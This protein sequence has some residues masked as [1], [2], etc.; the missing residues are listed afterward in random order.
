MKQ[1][2]HS[3]PLLLLFLTA[4]QPL[5]AQWQ[6]IHPQSSINQYF[7]AVVSPPNSSLLYAAGHSLAISSDGGNSWALQENFK[8]PPV[9]PASAYWDIC[10]TSTSTAFLVNEH[11]IFKTENTGASWKTVL[12]LSPNNAK[13]SSSAFFRSLFFVS[14]ETGF[15]VGDFN[16]I[17]KTTDGGDTW[18][19]LSWDSKTIPY[20]AITDVYFIDENVG[21]VSG[22]QSDD[23]VMNFGFTQFVMKTVD[24]GR[25]WQQVTIPTNWNFREINIQFLNESEGFAHL[26]NSQEY[27]ETYYTLD[28]GLS[29]TKNSP[30]N[31]RYIHKAYWQNNGKG[32]LYGI[33]QQSRILLYRTENLG[34][35]WEEVALPVFLY[36][37]VNIITDFLFSDEHKGVAVGS[38]GSILTTQDGGESWVSRNKAY[39]HFLAFKFY[40]HQTG[41]ASSGRGLFKTAD[42]GTNWQMVDG[43]VYLPIADF[44]LQNENNGVLPGYRGTAFKLTDGKLSKLDLPVTFL[45]RS[46]M[47]QHQDSLLICGTAIQPKGNFLLKS[48]DHGTT[49]KVLSIE[50]EGSIMDIEEVENSLYISQTSGI[51]KSDDGGHSW[52]KISSFSQDYLQHVTF[53]DAN[54]AVA[55]FSAARVCYSEDG[56]ATW[57]P[58]AQPF[59]NE[60][61]VYKFLAVNG[62]T[63]YACGSAYSGRTTYGRIWKSDDAGKSWTEEVIGDYIANGISDLQL[64]GGNLLASGGYGQFFRKSLGNR[65]SQWISFDALTE[66]TY[67]DADFSLSA[68][69]SS[70]LPV[71][72][73]SSNTSVATVNGAVVTIV[74]AGETIIRAHQP[75]NDLYEAAAVVAQPLTVHKKAQHISFN[76]PEEVN[77]GSAPIELEASSDAGL[78]LSFSSTNTAVATVDGNILSI[79]AP[80]ETTIEASQA[81]NNNYSPA[82]VAQALRVKVVTA[83]GDPAVA[84]PLVYPNPTSD[85][86]IFEAAPVQ[87]GAAVVKIYDG[88]GKLVEKHTGKASA[89]G[90]FTVDIRHLAP[91]IYTVMLEDQQI[92]SRRIVKIRAR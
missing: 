57:T 15:A 52:T 8:L 44:Y 56:G 34:Q 69:A 49:W 40:N 76:L 82:S 30:D 87:S 63:V 21:Y 2:K 29:W 20:R 58:V 55:Y 90:T 78:P 61:T 32:F 33:D 50:G 64:V 9:T 35:S 18:T 39:P 88:T 80:G 4:M 13:Y 19:T 38:G 75:G 65:Q 31:F 41:Y 53:L 5:L 70:A 77:A 27:D 83:A 92:I 46:Y 23:I 42:G 16:K 85:V 3:L 74:G 66:K 68:T 73:T 6:T 25:N 14:A 45:Y 72:Y 36:Q 37:D 7:G 81:G 22:Y 51:S 79:K 43:S 59:N 84:Q 62:S 48:G 54:R 28:G 24:G 71:H 60:T 67:L 10:F 17:F 12:E 91:G 11:K 86:I 47:L 89:E 1:F 26:T